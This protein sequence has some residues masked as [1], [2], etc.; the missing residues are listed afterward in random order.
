MIRC[1]IVDDEPLAREVLEMYISRDEDLTLVGSC[2]NAEEVVTLL[3]NKSVDVLFLDIQM[4]GA[5]GMQLAKTLENP[6]LI[7][8]TT[9]YSQYAVEGFE[10]NAVDYLLKP[11][12][13]ERFKMSVERIK[14]QIHYKRLVKSTTKTS[15]FLFVRADY[16]DIKIKFDEILYIEGLKDYVKIVT[17]EKRVI[18]L[19]NIKGMMERLPQN[20]FIRV[21][22]SFIVSIKKV[23]SVKGNI[24]I[25]NSKEIP[26]GL[27]YK[28]RFKKMM[29]LEE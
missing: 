3:H 12:S 20:D 27:T 19:T 6:P 26:I 2:K 1:V 10:V 4:P 9:A 16:Q 28:D 14:D 22:K 24:L 11:I 21:H 8:F 17:P 5:C 7:V 13:P 18:T 25:I 15:E 29:G 23:E